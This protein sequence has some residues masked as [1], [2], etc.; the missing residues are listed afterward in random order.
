MRYAGHSVSIRDRASR[1]FALTPPFGVR[2]L[3]AAFFF[4]K[5]RPR[6]KESRAELPHSK[7]GAAGANIAVPNLFRTHCERIITMEVPP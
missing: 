5:R 7:G 3:G 6:Q 2:R 1:D 4:R